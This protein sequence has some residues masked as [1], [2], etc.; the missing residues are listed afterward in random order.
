MW[1]SRVKLFH[2]TDFKSLLKTL[3]YL[4]IMIFFLFIYLY[5]TIVLLY[6]YKALC[7]H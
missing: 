6:F 2:N 5:F 3:F 1:V 7:N 4:F